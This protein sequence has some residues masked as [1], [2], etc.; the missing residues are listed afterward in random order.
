L[1]AAQPIASV[2]P[3]ERPLG[4]VVL[5]VLTL[6]LQVALGF[7]RGLFVYLLAAIVLLLSGHHASPG[8]GTW[9]LVAWFAPLAW[10]VLALPYAIGSGWWFV[11]S[12]G[13]RRPSERE[14]IAVE[15]ALDTV[16]QSRPGIRRPGSWWVLDSPEVNARVRGR[17]LILHRGAI[18]SRWLEAT[19]AHELGHLNSIDGSLIVALDRM[20]IPLRVTWPDRGAGLLGFASAFLVMLLTGELALFL[21]RP[22]WGAYL[23]HREYQA[24]LFAARLGYAEDL[25]QSL[26]NEGLPFDQP[27]PFAWLRAVSHPPTELRIDRL[28]AYSAGEGS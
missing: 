24:D 28:I 18:E 11:Q 2:V 15:D 1:S 6:A 23:R 10:S 13:A 27:I 26:E 5:Y 17:T 16:I 8:A 3:K 14:R 19:L 12:T 20:V 21:V 25:A 9:G 22:I 4:W 7:A